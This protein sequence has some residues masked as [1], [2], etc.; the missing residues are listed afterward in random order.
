MDKWFEGDV[1]KATLATDGVIGFAAGPRSAGTGYVL[2]IYIYG[3]GLMKKISY[4]IDYLLLAEII[5][6]VH[7]LRHAPI[8]GI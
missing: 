7:I 2:G 6:V 5:H 4:S 8:K 1:L 3:A